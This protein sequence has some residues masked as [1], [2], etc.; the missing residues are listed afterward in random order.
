MLISEL[1]IILDTVGSIM[2]YVMTLTLSVSSYVV[3]PCPAMLAAN[4][5]LRLMLKDSRASHIIF[6]A[7]MFSCSIQ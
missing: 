2:S 5:S 6:C 1:G 7:L 4:I 3:F